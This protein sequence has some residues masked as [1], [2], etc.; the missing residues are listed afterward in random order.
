MP[1][2]KQQQR[3]GNRRHG[4][5]R[6]YERLLHAKCRRQPRGNRQRRHAGE[7]VAKAHDRVHAAELLE[8][9]RRLHDRVVER[10]DNAPGHAQGNLADKGHAHVRSPHVNQAS[11]AHGQKRHKQRLKVDQVRRQTER[12]HGAQH[13][14]HAA[15]RREP[16]HPLD[17]DMQ[18]ITVEE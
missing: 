9:G 1:A 8:R 11:Q 15:G 14:A 12:N 3:R 7:H 4:H 6:P 17:T 16:A 2:S 13:R 5:A 10:V 18:N